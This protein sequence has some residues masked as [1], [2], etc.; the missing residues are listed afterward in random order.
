MLKLELHAGFRAKFLLNVSSNILVW[1]L[2]SSAVVL[3][4]GLN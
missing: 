4:S 1:S 2:V 3:T